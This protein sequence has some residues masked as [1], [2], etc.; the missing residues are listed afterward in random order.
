[1]GELTAWPQII[2]CAMGHPCPCTSPE[3]QS[4]GSGSPEHMPSP[5]GGTSVFCIHGHLA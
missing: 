3:P 4:L 1:M 2:L 5:L